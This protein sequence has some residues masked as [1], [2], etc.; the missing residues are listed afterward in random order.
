MRVLI[1]DDLETNRMLLAY[2]V[3]SL[4]HV[5]LTCSDA[6]SALSTYQSHGADLIFMDVVMPKVDG[7]V[8][9]KHLKAA[10]GDF[11]TP[12]IF[13][14]ALQDEEALVRCLEY[15]DDYLVRPFNQAMFN[16]K[17]NAH[18]RTIELQKKSQQQHEELT[19]LHSRLLQEQ[20]MAQHVFDHATQVNHQ[21]CLNIQTYLSSASQFNGDV[22][23]IAKSPAGGVY[24]ML[25]D[26]TGHGLP[27]ALGSLP[28]SQ[29][30]HSLVLKQLS[31]GDLAKQMN[32]VLTE[33]LPDYMF[34]A[35]VITEMNAE[36]D[37][38]KVW[39][40]GL[41]ETLIFDDRYSVIE[42]IE[43][44]HV[45]LGIIKDEEFSTRSL[46]F[47]LKEGDKVI[48]Y[49]DGILEA[50]NTMGELFG[51]QRFE[52]V[53]ARSKCDI[54]KVRKGLH[55]F[56]GYK[57]GMTTQD[58]DISLVC[59]SAGEIQ[60]SEEEKNQRAPSAYDISR[61][62]V[63][64]TISMTLSIREL[65]LGSPVSQLA[66]MVGEATGLYSHVPSISLLLVEMFNNALDHGV[67]ELPSTIKSGEKGFIEYYAQR[68][69]RLE[70][71]DSG[72]ITISITHQLLE[73][74]GEL[75][76]RVKDSGRGFH[77]SEEVM[78]MDKSYGRG[79]SIIKQISES[80]T[81]TDQGRCINVI[82]RY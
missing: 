44:L 67:L 71:K 51:K 39:S 28:L 62:P 58:D 47:K 7:Y 20:E 15:G 81:F 54:S 4:G 57:K 48:I 22:L 9:A 5:A 59:I 24:T 41:H 65:R 29:L 72:E 33:F 66:D 52:T 23:L 55:R 18:I 6:E 77:Y 32:K 26:F 46:E 14:T 8:A 36:G 61:V 53:L 38:L 74:G 37:L 73:R 16:A 3:E 2:L 82:Y 35:A 64:W 50:S 79:L 43:S 12:I 76:I 69:Q 70:N 42:R 1:V 45:P 11:F 34:C 80:M 75:D 25:G 30:F 49:T 19:Y 17:V 78:G 10:I 40:G 60:F 27:A 31:V 21:N 56:M 13:I 68:S 63:P